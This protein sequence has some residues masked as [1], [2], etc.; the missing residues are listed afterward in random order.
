MATQAKQESHANG[1]MAENFRSKAHKMVD[2]TADKASA[3]EHLVEEKAQVSSEKL[4]HAQQ[5]VAEDIKKHYG[6]VREK[7]SENPL[8]TL[9]VAFAAGVITSQLLSRK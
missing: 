8:L 2:K 1:S 9:G 3:A 7:A 6:T 5:K 4:H